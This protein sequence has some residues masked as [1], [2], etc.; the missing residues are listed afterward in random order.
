MH[1]FWTLVAGPLALSLTTGCHG[2]HARPE[3]G[4][5]GTAAPRTPAKGMGS[6]VLTVEE[7]A[8]AQRPLLDL[9]R[10]RLPGLEVRPTI[11]CPE[12]IL[13]GR[14]TIMTPSSPM[15]YVNGTRATNTCILEEINTADLS[16]V[17]VYPG[18][19]PPRAGYRSYPYGVILIFTRTWGS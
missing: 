7:L 12:V 10:Q 13:R 2:G 16:R 6:T 1:W 4:G 19:V 15:V 9:L 8:A 17:E 14:S 3:R 18:G 5:G 11:E